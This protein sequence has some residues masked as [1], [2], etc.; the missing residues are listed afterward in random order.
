MNR[1]GHE[2]GAQRLHKTRK[3]K[4]NYMGV[5]QNAF[6]KKRQ[7]TPLLHMGKQKTQDTRDAPYLATFLLLYCVICFIILHKISSAI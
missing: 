1:K 5:S 2:S 3:Q 7:V 4:K 6:F